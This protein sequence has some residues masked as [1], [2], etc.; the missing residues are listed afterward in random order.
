MV[1]NKQIKTFKKM[2]EKI[3]DKLNEKNYRVDLEQVENRF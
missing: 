3:T 1:S 2:W